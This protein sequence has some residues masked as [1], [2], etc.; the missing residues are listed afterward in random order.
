[1]W[2]T[3]EK[4]EMGRPLVAAIGYGHNFPEQEAIP[5]DEI[6]L[7]KPIRVIGPAGELTMKPG[8]ENYKAVSQEALVKGSYLVIADV[9]PVFWTKTPD[10]WSQKPKS[11]EPQALNCG[12]F[13]ENAKGIVNVGG[14]AETGVIGKPA[15]LP[16]E[17]VPLANPAAIKPGQRLALK[18]LFEG[19]PLAGAK[20]EGRFAG[21]AQK[22][23]DGA[24]AFSD[25]SGKD[26]LVNFVPLAGGDWIVTVR[27]V[28]PFP[29]ADKCD[30]EDFG[31]SLFFNIAN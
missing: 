7:F 30:T 15:G 31:T 16:L 14:A 10:G 19:Q 9:S 4:P 25:V 28:R 21:F 22:A 24:K 2:A 8:S 29:E 27:N 13:I 1:M 3:S 20:V 12:L 17:I 5:A 11:E 23:S 6:S 26:G 18:V